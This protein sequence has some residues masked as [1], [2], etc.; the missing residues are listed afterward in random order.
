[1]IKRHESSPY[2]ILGLTWL[3]YGSFYLNRL[4]L[5][6]VIPLI[7]GDLEI[8]HT[9][10]GLISTSFFVFY[11]I[12]QI[13]A[14]YIADIVGPKKIITI[15]AILSSIANFLFGTGQSLFHLIL[16]QSL[17]GLGQS[18]CWGPSVKLVT[19]WFPFSQRGRAIGIYITCV[20]TFIMIA[21]G[22]SGSLGRYFGWRM[23]FIIPPIILLIVI[24]FFWWK[25]ED[26]PQEKIQVSN[27]TIPISQERR[28]IFVIKHIPLRFTLISYFCLMMIRYS[29]IIW[30]PSYLH[31]VH[32]LDVMTAGMLS[33]VYPIMGLIA[34]PLGGYVSDVIF[35]GRR[36][37]LIIFGLS[38]LSVFTMFL[39]QTTSMGWSLFLLGGMGFFDQFMSALYFTFAVDLLPRETV[40]TGSSFLNAGASLGSML[41]ISLSGLII[42]LF[43]SYHMLFVI[44]SLIAL[45]GILFTAFIKERSNKIKCSATM[46]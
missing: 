8:S 41:S 5:A 22:L 39:S 3:V 6:P 31:E 14:G 40:S 11:A 34:H 46:R 10:I 25:V 27:A 28:L 19:N 26:H 35:K 7:M 17:N 21:Y 37:P 13:P 33:S 9:Q 29:I 24:F 30:I 1:M 36:V 45:I 2:I 43:K 15:G 4:N 18:S 23:S 16:F 20:S 44:L 12:V 38:G 42:A 32:H